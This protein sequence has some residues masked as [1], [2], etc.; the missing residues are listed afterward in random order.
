MS[1]AQIQAA[2]VKWLWN[3]HPLTRGLFFAVNNNSEHVARATCSE[4]LF[5]A[6]N[7]PLVKGWVFHSH[8]THAACICASL[9]SLSFYFAAVYQ[10][11]AAIPVNPDSPLAA[12]LLYK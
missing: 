4:L 12:S 2:C 8:F 5:T 1:E 11:S 10:L 7:S 9:I 3:T 6:K